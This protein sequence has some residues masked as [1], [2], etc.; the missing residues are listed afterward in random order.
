MGKFRLELM[1]KAIES[2]GLRKG[3]MIQGFGYCDFEFWRDNGRLRLVENMVSTVIGSRR[4]GKS[5]RTLQAIDELVARRVIK[6]IDH[7]CLLD[8]EIQGI[9]I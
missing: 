5:F 6:S 3:N 8:F 1:L 9:P 4:A 2:Q 7:V